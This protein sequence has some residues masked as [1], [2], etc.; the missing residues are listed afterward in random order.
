GGTICAWLCQS[1]SG[2]GHAHGGA[3]RG[4]QPELRRR[5]YQR[6]RAGPLPAV[7]TPGG[8][9]DA[10]RD[11]RHAGVSLLVVDAPRWRCAWHV[12]RLRRAR[13]LATHAHGPGTRQRRRAYDGHDMTS[14]VPTSDSRARV[15][16]SRRIPD[17]GLDRILAQTSAN[18][19]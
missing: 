9:T 1:H 13:R 18:V 17:E 8:P 11:A 7:D 10:V 5:R 3:A 14:D 16:V 4:V 2:A 15:F 19:W 12:W 6:R